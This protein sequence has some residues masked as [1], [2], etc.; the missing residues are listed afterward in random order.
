MATNG[1]SA[2]VE[3]DRNGGRAEPLDTDY[4]L[5]KAAFYCDLARARQLLQRGADPNSQD[6][7]GTPPPSTWIAPTLRCCSDGC[8]YDVRGKRSRYESERV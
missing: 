3:V 4:E 8:M 5:H 1:S 6:K 2:L 7:H